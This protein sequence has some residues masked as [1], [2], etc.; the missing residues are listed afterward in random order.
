VCAEAVRSGLAHAKHTESVIT[1]TRVLTT[2]D[3]RLLEA[4]VRAVVPLI[5]TNV[6]SRERECHDWHWLRM[7]CAV[8]VRVICGG[9]GQQI[10]WSGCARSHRSR[11]SGASRRG[12][13]RRSIEVRLRAD[14]ARHR[15]RGTASIYPA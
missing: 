14:A 8:G 3:E 9:F 10:G 11:A 1:T 2:V 13:I 12:C 6:T 15:R 5:Y 4:Q 7:R